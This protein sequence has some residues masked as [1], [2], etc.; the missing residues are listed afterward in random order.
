MGPRGQS[1]R[2][3]TKRI[4]QGPGGRQRTRRGKELGCSTCSVRN[5][6]SQ[7]PKAS[8][9][10]SHSSQCAF[11]GL[12]KSAKMKPLRKQRGVGRADRK[13]PGPAPGNT[14][15]LTQSTARARGTGP[16]SRPCSQDGRPQRLGNRASRPR[17]PATHAGLAGL[18]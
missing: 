12:A 2:S 16:S 11:R 13:G 5:K 1:L 17:R 6:S 3:G 18:R 7:H 8:T 14:G 15:H 4:A 9:G 10:H